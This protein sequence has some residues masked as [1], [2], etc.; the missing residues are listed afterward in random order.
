[1]SDLDA[2]S[3]ELSKSFGLRPQH[4]WAKAIAAVLAQTGGGAHPD[5]THDRAR[6]LEDIARRITVGE[7]HFFRHHEQLARA[8]EALLERG[9]REE[10]RVTVWCAGCAS[11]EEPYSLAMLMY[12]RLLRRLPDGVEILA[13][14]LNPDVIER[15]KKATYTAWSFRG[16]P[17][18]AL[19]HFTA[20]A[21][22]NLWLVTPEVRSAVR[23]EAVSCQAKAPGFRPQSFDLVSFRN[24]AIYF[25]PRA[26][27]ALYAEFFRILREGGLLA[28]GPSDPRPQDAQFQFLG[29]ADHAPLYERRRAEG[30]PPRP[31]PRIFQPSAYVQPP[32]SSP[33]CDEP[34]APE[35][36]PEP[37][38]AAEPR[39]S[40]PVRLSLRPL[41]PSGLQ[42]AQRH[43]DRGETESALR[44]ARA[45]AEGEP[46][47]GM[48]QRLLG[49]IE[50]E[51]GKPAAAV[52]A[53]RQS[54][55][56]DPDA[57]LARCFYAVALQEC[58]EQ[59]QALL[60][61]ELVEGQL[62]RRPAGDLLEDGETRASELALTVAF[63]RGEWR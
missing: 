46:A 36:L 8:S 22:R 45:L 35:L 7:T 1:V 49:Q 13:T 27:T 20:D 21:G 41:P 42:T 47:S 30:A 38:L 5:D 51:L 25:E 19:N 56:L 33:S 6:V 39:R 16:T 29:Y 15:A 17:S 2:W 52:V 4:D 62:S 58:G 57:A 59:D 55:F 10:R 12:R 54:V 48:A 37:R 26:V 28:L 3:M 60:Q 32:R 11:G 43:A 31:S 53:L 40:D 61:L 63:L 34:R 24:V 23:F 50:L 18:W 44:V 9:A 14:D